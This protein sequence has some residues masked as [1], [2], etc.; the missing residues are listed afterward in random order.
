MDLVELVRRS[1]RDVAVAARW[2]TIDPEALAAFARRLRDDGS[3]LDGCTG[4]AG[5][6]RS[7][8]TDPWW[9]GDVEDPELRAA[10]VL[11]LAAINFGSGW[12]DV[13]HKRPGLSGATTV[14]TAWRAGAEV[15]GLLDPHPLATVDAPTMRA[16]LGQPD[17]GSGGPITTLM[18]HFASALREIGAVTTRQFDGRFLLLADAGAGSAVALATILAALPVFD[19]RADHHGVDVCFFKRAQLAAAEVHR[20][21]PHGYFSEG[22]PGPLADVGRLTAFA[23]NLVPHVLRIEGALRFDRALRERIDRGELLEP[24]GAQEVEIRA[25]GVHAVELLI[26]ELRPLGVVINAADLDA[27]LWR[28][29]GS[30]RCKTKPRHRCRTIYY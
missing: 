30:R 20:A 23:D 14:A 2:V 6:D 13:L 9:V 1:T 4:S 24:G 26:A 7:P 18:E 25:A 28:R 10:W 5:D 8:S 3:L 27:A 22:S 16:L 21:F 12:H 15:A 19:D 11:T 29:G 17:D